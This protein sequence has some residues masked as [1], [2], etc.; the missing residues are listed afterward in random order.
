MSRAE[1]AA[2][3]QARDAA[4]LFA[5]LGDEMRFLLLRRPSA[6]GPTSIAQLSAKAEVSRQAISKHLQVLAGVGLVRNSRRGRECRKSVTRSGTRR[7]WSLSRT[8]TADS[9]S[10]ASTTPPS[11]GK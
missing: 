7:R 2:A 8:Q 9:R 11:E 1:A 4:P 5:A 10:W 3:R 6:G